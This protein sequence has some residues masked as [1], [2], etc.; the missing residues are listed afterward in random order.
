MITGMKLADFHVPSK[1]ESNMKKIL[2]IDDNAQ[3]KKIFIKVLGRAGFFDVKTAEDGEQGLAMVRKELP[4]LVIVDTL[5]PLMNG[6]EV[7][8]TIKD[9]P[10]TS[11]VKVVMTT[12][13][14]DAVDAVKARSM[15][16]DEYCAKTSDFSH[17]VKAVQDIF[18]KEEE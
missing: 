2:V 9:D 12:G 17:L 18:S 7:C 11:K 1:R 10:E 3:D 14:I 6:F 15:G 8:K 4:D 5:L 16:A 13:A